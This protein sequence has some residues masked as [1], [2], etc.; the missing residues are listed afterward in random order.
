MKMNINHSLAVAVAG[1]L[2]AAAVL[3]VGA[4]LAGRPDEARVAALI[5][6]RLGQSTQPAA[7]EKPASGLSEKD[8]EALI[9]KRLGQRAAGDVSA[10][11]F[12]AQV[13]RGILAFIEKQRQAEQA[14]PQ[15]LAK[16]VPPPTP[17]DHVYG[18]RNA[19]V[20]LIEYSDFECP[21]CKRFHATAKQLVDRSNSRVNWVYRHFPLDSHNPGAQKQAEA[22]ECAAELGGN[23]A[24]WKYTDTI[25]ERTRSGGKGFPIENLVPL[26]AEIRLDQGVFRACLDSGKY[27]RKVQQQMRDGE[28]AGVNGTPGN[29]LLNTRTGQ[30]LALMGAYP[31][32]RLHEAAESLL[33]AQ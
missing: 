8:V 21:Y 4:Q 29:I 1:A 24:F 23:E 27:A 10:A 17:E 22:V 31:Y 5:D 3:Y 13:E 25:Y 11:E 9:D 30:A 32:E 28:R 15:Q 12:N 19:P 20:T 26:A 7:G 18:D 14:R 6:E 33:K 16:N 2:V